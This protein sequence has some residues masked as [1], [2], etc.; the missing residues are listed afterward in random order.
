VDPCPDPSI[1][2]GDVPGGPQARR[3]LVSA[4]VT[5]EAGRIGAIGPVRALALRRMLVASAALGA[6]LLAHAVASGGLH[7]VSAA[8]ALWGCLILVAGVAGPRR[9]A[10]RERGVVGGLLILLPAQLL[11]HLA[12]G[13]APWMF[14]L[15]VHGSPALLTPAAAAAHVGLAVVLA[16][17]LARAERLLSA[18]QAFSRAVR[19]AIVPR[20][21]RPPRPAPAR[22]RRA[23]LAGQRF[24]RPS[25]A[26]GPPPLSV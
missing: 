1:L 12:M 3:R 2:W 8:P 15:Y 6:T 5:A 14:G 9:R 24:P 4:A 23:R 22:P 26:R 19:A 25:G 11:I 20:L 17:L 16:V 18:M 13:V 10:W 21:G 7:V